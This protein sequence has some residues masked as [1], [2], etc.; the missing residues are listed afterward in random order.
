MTGGGERHIRIQI[1]CRKK[2]TTLAATVRCSRK[3]FEVRN[4]AAFA[5]RAN[6]ASRRGENS[7]IH[8]LDAI[9]QR[10]IDAWPPPL[11]EQIE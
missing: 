8:R 11:L 9:D 4:C 1:G 6:P 10:L 3:T 2:C 7:K 5:G